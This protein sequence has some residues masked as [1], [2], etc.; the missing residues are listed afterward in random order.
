ME[1]GSSSPPTPDGIQLEYAFR[2]GFPT[3]NNEVEYEAFLVGLQLAISIGAEQIKV[4]I[5]LQL[6]INQV[7]QQYEARKDN[8][9][10]YLDLVRE[11]ASKL[12][13]LSI[14]QIPRE[15]NTQADRLARLALSSEIDLQGTR[16]EYLS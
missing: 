3:S 5:D 2:F 9:V 13:G 6:I 10:A 11:V 16:V 15:E 12:K 1:R 8:M 14:T 7:L 4:Y